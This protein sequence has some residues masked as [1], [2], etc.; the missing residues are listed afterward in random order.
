[1]TLRQEVPRTRQKARQSTVEGRVAASGL[2]RPDELSKN[3]I[4][5]KPVAFDPGCG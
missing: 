4:V 5:E 2:N 1:M 3:D